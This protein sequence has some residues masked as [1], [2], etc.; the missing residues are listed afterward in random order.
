MNSRQR[1]AAAMQHRVP[2]RVPVM[3]QLALGHYFLNTGLPPHRIWFTS[4]GF[5][6]AFGQ[7][8]S[9]QLSMRNSLECARV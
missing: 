3:C 8:T 7:V 5:A 9:R 4:E 2:D 6:A 1:I